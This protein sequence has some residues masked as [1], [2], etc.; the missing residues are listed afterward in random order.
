MPRTRSTKIVATLGP[1]SSSEEIV[2]ALFDGGVDVFRLNFSHGSHEEHAARYRAIRDV[3][4][5]AGRPIGVL[6]DLQGPKLRVG[7][8]AG[9]RA[10]LVAGQRFRLDLADAPGDAARVRLPHEELYAALRPGLEI[11]LDDGRLRLRVERCGPE[12][13]ET[14]AL[15]SGTLSDHKGVNVPG[16]VLPLRAVTEKDRKD[17][18]FGLDLGVD[19]VELS[20]VQRAADVVEARELIR[21][22][23]GIVAKI[24]KP[25]A[26]SAIEEIAAVSDAVMIARGDLGVEM[27]LEDVPAVQK[28][29]VAVCR[30][31]G[32]PVIVATQMLESMCKSSSP[33]RAEVSDVATAVYDGADAVMLSAESAA[34]AF[35]VEAVS[36]MDRIVA[37]VERDP[38]HRRIMGA[39]HPEPEAT[40]A[41][42][43]IEAAHQVAETVSAASIVAFST[44]GSTALRASRSR[45][46]VRI[47]GLTPDLR[48]SRRLALAWGVHAVR[49][50]DVHNFTEMVD[51]ACRVATAEGLA[52][53]GDRLVITAGV[54]F[55]TPG[56]TNTLRVAAIEPG[57]AHG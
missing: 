18:E 30:S 5:P 22:R 21:G 55:G 20:F 3:E 27:A 29:I 50:E 10:A 36:T 45:P 46:C 9:G 47:L 34:G 1:A 24:E 17:L 7:A 37:S 42:A 31:H 53:P 25:S 26:V 2:R 51:R 12:F 39:S 6:M 8:F 43:I 57:H 13:V 48:T 40:T 11:L 19:W 35:P 4:A 14:V 38:L 28:R 44:S 16:V 41:D 52:S 49:T 54:P 23:A 32:R 15:T 56:A 33:T